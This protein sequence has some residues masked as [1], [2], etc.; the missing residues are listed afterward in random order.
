MHR[1][2]L[3]GFC[4]LLAD[5]PAE[6]LWVRLSWNPQHCGRSCQPALER[7]LKSIEAVSRVTV[8]FEEGT[9]QLQWKPNMPYEDR[10]V[11]TPIA[12]VGLG[13]RDVRIKVRGTISHDS[14]D[15]FITSLG[16]G[17]KMPVISAAKEDKSRY[18][19]DRSLIA[20]TLDNATRDRLIQTEK[21]H[22]IVT[23]D[24]LIYMPYRPPIRLQ[25]ENIEYHDHT[26]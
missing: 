5:L 6:V 10:A 18:A 23:I 14:K 12:W 8:N 7:R 16:D 13:L 21:D 2:L 26:R 17:T 1:L 25:L 24:G 19:V 11:R 20:T 3:L 15:V 4:L 9:A 22:E